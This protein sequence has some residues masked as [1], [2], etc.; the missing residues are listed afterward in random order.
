MSSKLPKLINDPSPGTREGGWVRSVF[1]KI[2]GILQNR[3][4]TFIHTKNVGQS[5]H[6]LFPSCTGLRAKDLADLS[7]TQY[8]RF[9]NEL[10]CL[11]SL[12]SVKRLKS[13]I[14]SSLVN[15]FSI[16]CP[17]SVANAKHTASRVVSVDVERLIKFFILQYQQNTTEIR[18]KFSR[19]E[20][21]D[22]RRT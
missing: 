20:F 8:D 19:D 6:C 11:V 14:D 17:A 22:S 9:R 2:G 3:S 16:S 4:F 10:P 15:L 1:F 13:L 12:G 5:V 18:I 21:V 7:D